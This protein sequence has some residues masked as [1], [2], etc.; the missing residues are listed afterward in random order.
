M[1]NRTGDTPSTS[2]SMVPNCKIG[3]VSA[4]FAPHALGRARGGRSPRRPRAEPRP[5][6]RPPLS[7]YLARGRGPIRSIAMQSVVPSQER[8]SYNFTTGA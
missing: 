2:V 7:R 8:S 5:A 3:D 1:Q 4:L 6:G